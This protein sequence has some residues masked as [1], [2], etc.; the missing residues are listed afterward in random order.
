MNHTLLLS[1]RLTACSTAATSA[2]LHKQLKRWQLSKVKRLTAHQSTATTAITSALTGLH[3][4]LYSFCGGDVGEDCCSN[5]CG[6][7]ACLSQQCC[8]AFDCL[9]S[10]SQAADRALERARRHVFSMVASSSFKESSIRLSSL[11]AAQCEQSRTHR[12]GCS[13]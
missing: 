9:H 7:E 10:F 3:A 13:C 11:L 2:L 5:R 6:S 1:K 4:S 8:Y 12:R